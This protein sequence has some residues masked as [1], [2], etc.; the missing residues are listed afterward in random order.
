[1]KETCTNDEPGMHQIGKNSE[2][3]ANPFIGLHL[4]LHNPD[5]SLQ[6]VSNRERKRSSNIIFCN[7]RSIA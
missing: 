5:S 7:N 6:A 4:W 1:M 2:P 3:G